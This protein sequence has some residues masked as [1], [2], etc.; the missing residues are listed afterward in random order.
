MWLLQELVKKGIIG[1]EKAE[2]LKEEVESSNQSEEEIVLE[3]GIIDEDSLFEMKSAYLKIPRKKIKPEDVSPDILSQVP[4]ET[5]KYYHMVPLL[6]RGNVLEVGMVYPEDLAAQEALNFLTRSSN[7]AYRVFLISETDFRRILN[8]YEI[9]KN[10]VGKALGELK[11]E[12]KERREGPRPVEIQRMVEEAPV[13]KMV[14]VILRYGVDGKASD[15]HIEPLK[16]RMRVR[17]RMM[18][19]LHSSIFLPIRILPSIV[20]RVKILSNL[21]IDETR[22]P[23]DGRFSSDV[24]GRDIDFRVSTFPTARGE[25][26]AIR[27]LDPRVGL[28]KIEDL[29]LSERNFKV[30]K[31]TI[32]KPYGLIIS[33]GPTGC[34][35]STTQYAILQLLNR[36]GVNIVTLEDPVEYFIE[37]VNQSQIRPEIGYDFS[38]GLRE[39]LRQDPDIIMVG[40]IR[41]SETAKLVTHAALTGHIVL[42]TLHTNNVFGVVPRLIDLGVEP[43]LIVSSFSVAASQRLVRVLCPKCRKRVKPKGRIRDIILRE[44][45]KLP[46]D[47]RIK[48]GIKT[49]EDISIFEAVPCP[50]CHNTGYSGRIALFEILEMTPQL[51]EIILKEP[52][53]EKISQEAKRQGMIT[54]MQDGI[55]KVLDGITTIE[56]VLR[57]TKER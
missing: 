10:V 57:T 8:R 16:N 53:E 5:A 20:S 49:S 7:I 55:L 29:G 48:K 37:G 9:P 54:M 13:S 39:I 18:G 19:D 25:K 38:Q 56:E 14:A 43:F 42:S 27:I 3:K 1:K 11:E 22:I 12:M 45:E 31:S 44:I 15:I 41:D 17:F 50:E 35:K 33:S 32:E 46:E 51:S 40:E 52:S 28:K 34:G 30:I 24:M 47:V 36:D 2:S 26:I 4:E 6:K 21:R 23:Q